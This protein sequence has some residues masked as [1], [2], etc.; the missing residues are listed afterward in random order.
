M[1]GADRFVNLA[2][3]RGGNWWRIA[4]LGAILGLGTCQLTRAQT[5]T[6]EI[7]G[8]ERRC[9]LDGFHFLT[10]IADQGVLAIRG[11]PGVDPN[12]WGYTWYPEAFI[13]GAVLH[14]LTGESVTA[15]ADHIT[16]TASGGVSRGSDDTY[17]TWT[18]QL[19]FQY[20][21]VAKRITGSGS[22]SI[23]LPG[24]LSGV[25]D[26]NL[27]RIASNYL[28]NVPLLT[29][30]YGDTGDMTDVQADEEVQHFTWVPPPPPEDPGFF[31]QDHT[32]SLLVQV[33]GRL[34]NVDTMAQGHPFA[35]AAAYKPSVS[36]GLVSSD[37]G[38]AMIFGALYDQSHNQDFAADNVGIT[39]LVLSSSPSTEF[40]FSVT[41]ESSAL[42]GDGNDADFDG[43]VD[44]LDPFPNCGTCPGNLSCPGGA[45]VD[46][47]AN[48]GDIEV[49]V[50]C[51]LVGSATAPGCGCADMDANDVI[52]ASDAGLFVD[53][54]LGLSMA[55]L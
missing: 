31:P 21:P 50:G 54:I 7:V 46:R 19:T 42:P 14:H 32:G 23:S 51:L 3:L 41:F 6:V 38:I 20:D 1:S 48:G 45:T 39:P 16:V 34:N 9:K 2:F 26:L 24:T 30:T 10:V 40:S 5:Y 49:F 11:H 27:Y 17:G 28:Q 4:C 37:P 12:G 22:Y 35:I 33:S 29:C 44:G 18:I 52:D 43:I 55:C 8:T 13:A 25:G 15:E 53:A 36:V 47:Q